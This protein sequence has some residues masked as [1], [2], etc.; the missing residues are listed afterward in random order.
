MEYLI[1]DALM[2]RAEVECTDPAKHKTFSISFVEKY[3]TV[4]TLEVYENYFR[5]IAKE[6][7]AGHDVTVKQICTTQIDDCGKTITD[8]NSS[9][10]APLWK[11]IL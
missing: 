2:I 4:L 3:N 1:M 7:Y 9:V 8:A 6:K 5:G 11:P 10:D